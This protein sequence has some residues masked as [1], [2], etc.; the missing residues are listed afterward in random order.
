MLDS[1]KENLN[2]S[3][4]RTVLKT[5]YDM[6]S[7][8]T[9][10]EFYDIVGETFIFDPE[11]F[12]TK[13][14][15]DFMEK[16][17][18]T[19]GIEKRKEMERYIIEKYSLAEDEKIIYELKGNIIQ[20]ELA[21]KDTFQLVIS[22]KDADIFV[23]SKR[24]IGHG[25]LK[26]T[27]GESKKASIWTSSLWVFTGG[28]KRSE[29]KDFLIKS[30]PVFGYQFPTEIPK[31]LFKKKQ[32]VGYFATINKL[33]YNFTIKPSDK[34]KTGDHVNN[35]FDILRKDVDEVLAI[36]QEIY[37]KET[38]EQKIQKRILEVLSSMFRG[39]KML[40]MILEDLRHFS[41][42]DKIKVI[43]ETYKLDPEFFMGSIYP[44]MASWDFPSFLSLKEQLFDLLR[45]EGASI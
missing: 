17:A 40:N 19:I 16:M 42:S 1:I 34:S 43:L 37:D 33:K 41:D 36:I 5:L 6:A 38:S 21:D 23:T 9:D 10:S 27:G 11:L 4:I 15:N 13:L 31:S 18:K 20:K 45:K 39:Q 12:M 25:L 44:K 2:N 35:I 8:L 32:T 14:Y 28:T 24:L 22:V 7:E 29:R 3:K 30:C 26:V